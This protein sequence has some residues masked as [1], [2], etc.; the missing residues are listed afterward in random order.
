MHK[1]FRKGFRSKN[2]KFNLQIF[3]IIV[4]LILM[5][6][7]APIIAS[8]LPTPLSKFDV[9][10][11][12]R[13][14]DLQKSGNMKQAI[15]EMGRVKNP[16][17]KGHVLAQRYLHPTAWRSSYKELSE[18]L[19]HYNDHPDASRIYWLAKRR[20]PK[21]KN[22][23]SPK[24][25]LMIWTLE[26]MEPAYSRQQQRARP[27]KN[28]SQAVVRVRFVEGAT[29]ALLFLIVLEIDVIHGVKRDN[30]GEVSRLFCFGLDDKAFGKPDTLLQMV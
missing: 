13:L 27:I 8:Q 22:P 3:L 24:P 11:Y 28:R 5:S 25:L 6:F 20:K 29:G 26:L 1:Y 23:T 10:Q 17:L 30:S 19:A 4:T 2:K 12:R 16:I 9:D 18:W 15:R 7:N 14:L 21:V